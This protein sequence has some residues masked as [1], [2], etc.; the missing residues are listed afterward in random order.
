MESE[1]EALRGQ[2]FP[3]SSITC[4]IT[5]LWYRNAGPDRWKVLW[6]WSKQLQQSSIKT[7]LPVVIYAL[8]MRYSCAFYSV[9]SCKLFRGSRISSKKGGSSAWLRSVWFSLL[10]PLLPSLRH[11]YSVVHNS[12]SLSR[13]WLWRPW[14]GT[15]DLGRE[16][17]L[18][19]E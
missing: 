12:L 9:F 18:E 19:L 3:N 6:P 14:K 13:A 17:E 15:M 1:G 16:L 10:P 4:V 5:M 2:D 7:S 11:R 8:F